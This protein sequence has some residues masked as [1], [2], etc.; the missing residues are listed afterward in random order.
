MSEDFIIAS[1]LE[2][3][4]LSIFPYAATA[5]PEIDSSETLASSKHLDARSQ[6]RS[7]SPGS[8]SKTSLQSNADLRIASAR[9]LENHVNGHWEDIFKV[10]L[11]IVPVLAWPIFAVV[12]W[13][14]AV[15]AF[16]ILELN[17]WKDLPSNSAYVMIITIVLNLL[18]AFRTSVAYDRYAEG[19]KLWSKLYF[20]I[21][22]LARYVTVYDNATT[23]AE[24]EA[25]HDALHLLS[26]LASVVMDH[27]RA[28][29]LEQM[30]EKPNLSVPDVTETEENVSKSNEYRLADT[31]TNTPGAFLSSSEILQEVQTY[32]LSRPYSRDAT[33]YPFYWWI[34]GIQDQISQ[35]DRIKTTPSPLAYTIHLYQATLFYLGGIPFVTVRDCGAW[36]TI[37]ISAIVAFVFLGM[38]AIADEIEQPFG[39]D[40]RDLP[41]EKYCAEIEAAVEFAIERDRHKTAK[42]EALWGQ[43]CGLIPRKADEE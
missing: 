29:P 15:S 24:I 12:V 43:P 6:H 37:V 4:T 25:K 22:N 35:L 16:S 39:D 1:T 13:A 41:L 23:A 9:H 8:R 33:P 31:S 17:P 2:L 10:S 20:H 5:A 14:G 27:L 32:I 11:S 21:F 42:G 40:V 26:K 19:R 28:E 36:L 38:L 34:S 3:P 18:L 30:N 7:K